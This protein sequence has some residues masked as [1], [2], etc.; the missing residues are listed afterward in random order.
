[1]G[2]KSMKNGAYFN[3][4]NVVVFLMGVVIA[5]KAQGKNMEFGVFQKSDT[6]VHLT[7]LPPAPDFSCSVNNFYTVWYRE[8]DVAGQ[9]WEISTAFKGGKSRGLEE[10][11]FIGGLKSTTV[12]EF[13]LNLSW[14]GKEYNSLIAVRTLATAVPTQKTLPDITFKTPLVPFAPS[15]ARQIATRYPSTAPTPASV[16]L[17]PT[18]TFSPT[19]AAGSGNRGIKIL[20]GAN[21][22]SYNSVWDTYTVMLL[23]ATTNQQLDGY[24]GEV[25]L[26]VPKGV[27]KS[28]DIG[29][30]TITPC[31]QDIPVTASRVKFNG[32]SQPDNVYAILFNTKDSADLYVEGVLLS[33]GGN[34]TIVC[35]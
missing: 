21:Y 11:I 1:M 18:V 23:D 16:T 20:K 5:Q 32:V 22:I 3:L 29:M 19:P 30:F 9:K 24:I 10:S 17:P 15:V 25:S 33:T 28:N 13:Q 4:V 8:R 31:Q 7:W 14:D 12:Y 35:S 34:F 2:L 6:S 27:Y 26:D